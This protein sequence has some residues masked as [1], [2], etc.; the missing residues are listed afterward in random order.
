MN[1]Q[2]ATEVFINKDTL[3]DQIIFQL[4]EDRKTYSLDCIFNSIK[5]DGEYRKMILHSDKASYPK[6]TDMFI[7]MREDKN[8]LYDIIIPDEEENI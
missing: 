3:P 7:T 1:L 6:Y 4:N 2:K 5:V 8:V